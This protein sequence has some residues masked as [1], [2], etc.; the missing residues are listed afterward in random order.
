MAHRTDSASLW[1]PAARETVYDAFATPGALE[2]WLPPGDMSAT[3]VHFDF[4]EGG[5]YRMRLYYPDADYGRGKTS[6]DSDEVEVRLAR[7][8]DGRRIEQEVGFESADPAYG[9]VMRMTWTFETQGVG[10]LVS[11]R[12]EDVPDGILA[13]DH[14][15]AMALTLHNLASFVRTKGDG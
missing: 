14:E 6:A 15:V 13:E 1:I 5:S 7:I 12:A 9:G 4:R 8:V 10:T 3:M 2:R 11:I